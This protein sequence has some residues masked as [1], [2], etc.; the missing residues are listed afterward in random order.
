MYGLYIFEYVQL[1]IQVNTCFYLK[2]QIDVR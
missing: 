1:R 2:I